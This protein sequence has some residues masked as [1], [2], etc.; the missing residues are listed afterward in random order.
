MSYGNAEFVVHPGQ[1]RRIE[2]LGVHFVFDG[3]KKH[4]EFVG[5]Q[6]VAGASMVIRYRIF[7]QNMRSKAGELVFQTT[8]FLEV[9]WGGT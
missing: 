4:A 9:P 5:G 2:K 6:P 1:V 8:D 3:A 7:A